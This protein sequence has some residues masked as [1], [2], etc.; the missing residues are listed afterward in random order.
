M[1]NNWN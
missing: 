1:H